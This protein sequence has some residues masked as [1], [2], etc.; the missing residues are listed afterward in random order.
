M[1]S[2][3]LYYYVYCVQTL[4]PFRNKI[5]VHCILYRRFKEIVKDII[6]ICSEQ[7]FNVQF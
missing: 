4:H 1:L 2:V 7:K 6:I 5:F 3:C